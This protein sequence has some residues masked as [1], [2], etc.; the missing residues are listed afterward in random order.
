M[1]KPNCPN[2][3]TDTLYIFEECWQ[4]FEIDELALNADGVYVGSHRE[5]GEVI[6]CTRKVNC[7]TCDFSAP[8]EE[9]F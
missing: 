8:F 1:D 4:G 2:C 5:K 3:G 7:E 9:E 6:E